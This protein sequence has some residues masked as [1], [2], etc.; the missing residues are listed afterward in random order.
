MSA[1]GE[2]GGAAG[3]GGSIG[4]GFKEPL[5]R[6]PQKSPDGG[7]GGA[8]G[9]LLR[10]SGDGSALGI[11]KLGAL[12]AGS[13]ALT[14]W[15]CRS[16]AGAGA[17]RSATGGAVGCAVTGDVGAG[18]GGAGAG[19]AGGWAAGAGGEGACAAGLAAGAASAIRARSDTSSTAMPAVLTS[20]SIASTLTA[21]APRSAESA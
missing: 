17:G 15:N 14:A 11:K 1:R 21:F 8:G 19:G 2:G 7:A 12:G 9:G 13:G 3:R 10:G 18:A 20:N 4:G 16:T 5:G 6:A